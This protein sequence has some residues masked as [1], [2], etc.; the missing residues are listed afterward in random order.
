MKF[1]RSLLK[2]NSAGQCHLLR[3][4]FVQGLFPFFVIAFYVVRLVDSL[5]G[6]DGAATDH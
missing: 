3:K 5:V 1:E 2:L 4:L 6:E